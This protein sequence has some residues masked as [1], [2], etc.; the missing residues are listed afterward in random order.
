MIRRL[1]PLL[2]ALLAAPAAGGP[3]DDLA[4]HRQAL[5]AYERAVEAPPESTVRRTA[6]RDAVAAWTTLIEGR[7]A[8]GEGVSADLYRGLGNAHLLAGD[9]GRAVL[10]YRRAERLDPRD[11]RVRSSL[12]YA[13]SLVG[14]AAPEGGQALAED[15]LLWWRGLV[16]RPWILALGLAA[17]GAFWILAA[18]RVARLRRVGTGWLVGAAALAILPLGSLALE[19]ALGAAS[20]HAVIVG[21]PADAYNGPNAAVY[22]RTFEQPLAPGVEARVLE[23]R[24]EWVRLRLRSGGETWVRAEA[25][26]RVAEVAAG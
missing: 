14:T 21:G 18:L 12:T 19:E 11:P 8:A 10:A 23:E 9:V 3:D 15:A 5:E 25:V 20:G 24:G 16:P 13:R 6:L 7:L 2:L 17:S 22:P 26:E 4:L 1:L